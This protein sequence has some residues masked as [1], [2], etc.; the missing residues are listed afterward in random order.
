V[1]DPRKQAEEKQSF[2]GFRGASSGQGG[3]DQ[4]ER[5]RKLNSEGLEGLIPRAT[6]LVKLGGSFWVAFW[7]FMAA[8]IAATVL[9][10]LFTGFTGTN[11]IH[12]GSQSMAIPEYL[13]RELLQPDLDSANVSPSTIDL[14]LSGFKPNM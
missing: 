2:P 7:P 6:E 5:S 3:M 10:S 8:I 14:D 9:L 13:P 12:D 4:L 11:F 1:G